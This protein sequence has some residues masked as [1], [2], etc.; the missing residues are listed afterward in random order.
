MYFKH[1][2]KIAKK[3]ILEA[4]WYEIVTTQLGDSDF[5]FNLQVAQVIQVGSKMGTV[6]ML[7]TIKGATLMEVIAVDQTSIHNIARN[8][9]ALKIWT[10]L[11]H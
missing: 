6:M 1:E 7:Q 3:S 2:V 4:Q 8:A 5:I 11:L 10:V 9:S